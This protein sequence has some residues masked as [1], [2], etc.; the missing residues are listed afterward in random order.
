MGHTD[1]DEENA[2]PRRKYLPD[3][4]IHGYELP[5]AGEGSEL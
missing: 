3:P 5:G 4:A 2:D 1:D